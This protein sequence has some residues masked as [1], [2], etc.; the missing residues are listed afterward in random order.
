MDMHAAA[1]ARLGVEQRTLNVL[2][3]WREAHRQFSPRERAALAWAEAVN[4]VP[5]RTPSNQ[6]FEDVRGQFKER[7]IAEITFA[8]AAI[9]AFNM[10]NASFHTPVPEKPYGVAE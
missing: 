2:A 8:V 6:E 9:R 1:L 3:G 5:H 4:A 10:L 7:E